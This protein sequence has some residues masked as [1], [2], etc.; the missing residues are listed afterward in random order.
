MN[1]LITL[2]LVVAV[3]IL[4]G[5]G[6]C[7]DDNNDVTGSRGSVATVNV[8]APTFARSGVEFGVEIVAANVGLSN[9]RNGHVAISFESP[10]APHSVDASAGTSASISGSS[11]T[12]DLGTLDANTR[13][14]LQIRVVGTLAP[15]ELSRSAQ[16]RAELTGQ[17]ISAG[18]AVATD[19]VTITP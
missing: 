10:L 12:W 2:R 13:S 19:F 5:A 3:L 1:R 11:V 4:A 18:D 7:D 6:A 14:R 9:I 17:G 8:D 16:I 15:G